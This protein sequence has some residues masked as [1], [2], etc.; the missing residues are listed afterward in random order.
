MAWRGEHLAA[1]IKRAGRALVYNDA[2]TA[3]IEF[4]LILPM[5]F[6]LYIGGFE[7]SQSISVYRKIS[8]LTTSLAI[9][10]SQDAWENKG[11][12]DGEIAASAQI[13]TP[14]PTADLTVSMTQI[15][16]DSAVVGKGVVGWSRASTK[17]VK[18]TP[19]VAGTVLTTLPSSL[20][21]NTTYILVKTSYDYTVVVGVNEI[22]PIPTLN[23]QLY[24]LP[25]IGT[26]IPCTNCD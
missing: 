26:P 15:T 14:Y 22:N 10:V 20:A 17:G 25:R 6:I 24:I 7:A 12:L 3:V 13:M 16:T 1:A 8:D 2:G 19:Y 18:S 21:L 5:L 9:I 11:G 23:D 4:A